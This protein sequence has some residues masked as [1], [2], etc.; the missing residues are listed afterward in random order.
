MNAG[1]RPGP[2][3]FPVPCFLAMGIGT[4]Q[5]PVSPSLYCIYNC[6]REGSGQTYNVKVL[7]DYRESALMM[8]REAEV[9]QNP[10]F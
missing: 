8:C 7:V 3:S 2:R 5:I 6:E 1:E 9:R 4:A 10:D